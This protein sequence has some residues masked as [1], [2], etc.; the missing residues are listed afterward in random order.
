MSLFGKPKYTAT[1]KTEEENKNVK[2]PVGIFEKCKGCEESFHKDEWKKNLE[3]CPECGY[4]KTLPSARRV[5][6]LT[7]TDTFDEVDAGLLSVDILKFEGVASYTDKLEQY[8][9]KTGMNDAVVC[10]TGKLNGIEYALAVMDFSFL[11]ASMGSVVGE[12]ITR[13]TE[14]ATEKGI[15]LVIVT[16]S[17]G[18]RMYEGMFSL[19]QMAKTSGALERHKV[20]NLPYIV[21]MTNPTTAGVTASYA[22]LGS[23]I[24]AEPQ[25]LIGFAGPRVIK[26]TTQATLPEGFQTSEFLLKKGLIDRVIPRSE[27]RREVGLMLEYF[28]A[29]K[30]PIQRKKKS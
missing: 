9:K 11:G 10:G 5:E 16:A 19:M 28:T 20:K 6:L 26:D 8:R 30:Y 13:I 4:H 7:D 21:V 3:V 23:L 15:P 17:G 18:A 14:L 25:A 12:K 27:L 22:S 29:G 1:I 2:I 24:V